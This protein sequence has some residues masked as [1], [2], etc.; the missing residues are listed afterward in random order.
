M[1]TTSDD[2]GKEA[3]RS[4]KGIVFEQKLEVIH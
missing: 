3:N 2:Y 1:K 4:R